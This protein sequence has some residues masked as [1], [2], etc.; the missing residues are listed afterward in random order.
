MKPMR[1]YFRIFKLLCFVVVFFKSKQ[2]IVGL[3]QPFEV[4]RLF[5]TPCIVYVFN[6]LEVCR[7]RIKSQFCI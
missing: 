1:P 6:F 2:S 5:D 3:Q 4:G 7:L